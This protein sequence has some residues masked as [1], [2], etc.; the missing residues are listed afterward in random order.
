MRI[1]KFFFYPIV[2]QNLFGKPPSKG[3]PYSQACSGALAVIPETIL[4]SG[5]GN[6]LVFTLLT[7]VEVSKIALQFD[8]TNVFKN[9]MTG[10]LKH[11]HETRGIAGQFIAYPSLLYRQAAWT[12]LYFASLPGF[13]RVSNSFQLPLT[14]R[15]C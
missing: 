15:S 10:A 7:T 13:T 2:H 12:S 3:N 1:S 14:S 8:K 6:Y 11:V 5:L 9:S 4:I